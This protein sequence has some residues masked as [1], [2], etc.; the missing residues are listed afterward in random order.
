MTTIPASHLGSPA[1]AAL[2][3][4]LPPPP[5]LGAA[6]VRAA[7]AAGAGR[8]PVVID[9]DP[10]GTQT[11]AGV[12][13]VSRWTVDDLRWGVAGGGAGA[14]PASSCS[15]TPA[16]STPGRPSGGSP[17]SSP[18]SMRRACWRGSLM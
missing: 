16:A 2:A 15:P 5:L 10:T 12:P 1:F 8:L 14:P 9:D 13:L 6:D 11:V 17:R 4:E 18:R 3:A 7:I